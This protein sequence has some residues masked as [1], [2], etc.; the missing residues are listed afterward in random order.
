MSTNSGKGPTHLGGART[1]F[2]DDLTQAGAPQGV[3][4]DFAGLGAWG[5]GGDHL[6][7]ENQP[8]PVIL[9]TLFRVPNLV[10]TFYSFLCTA[11]QDM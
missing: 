1:Y 10:P 7:S 5:G 4:T 6:E 9:S 11:Q 3:K 2:G 8:S